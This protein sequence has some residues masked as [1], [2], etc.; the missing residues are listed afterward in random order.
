MNEHVHL[1]TYALTLV[2]APITGPTTY[3]LEKAAL[4]GGVHPDLLRHYSQIGLFT[5][6][7]TQA[8][9]E[10]HFDDEAVYELRRIEHY[11]RQHGVSR[12]TLRVLCALWRE[13]DAL[14]TEL[15]L[16]RRN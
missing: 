4:L 6:V 11:R 3:S 14:Q 9:V 5:K 13:I 8:G 1:N 15:R 16:L 10:L 2:R 7:R 12:R